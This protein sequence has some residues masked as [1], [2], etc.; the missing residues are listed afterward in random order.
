MVRAADAL[1]KAD[2]RKLDGDAAF[3]PA[4]AEFETAVDDIAKAGG[5][6]RNR[7]ADYAAWSDMKGCVFDLKFFRVVQNAAGYEAGENGFSASGVDMSK[8]QQQRIS[9]SSG[10]IAGCIKTAKSYQ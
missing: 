4:I 5:S 2:S 10:K 9:A 7:T 1:E 6:D 3:L 8:E